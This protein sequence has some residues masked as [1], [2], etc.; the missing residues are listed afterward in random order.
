MTGTVSFE[1]NVALWQ[2]VSKLASQGAAPA[3]T[4]L[5][6]HIAERAQKVTLRRYKKPSGAW[7]RA[8]PG[9]PP[10][11]STGKL[12]DAMYYI[13][14]RRGGIRAYGWVGNESDY[15]RIREF[16]CVVSALNKEDLHWK[17]SGSPV[18]GW[19]H[20]VLEHPPH[21]YLSPTTEEAVD[22]GSLADAGRDEFRKY[23]P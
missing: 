4:A 16:G 1:E 5:V 10:A 17:D 20:K 3:A 6:K 23:D 8:R 14:A 21:P 19:F 2:G 7:N 13:P 12:A 15:A 18:K 9:E 11:L 22:D